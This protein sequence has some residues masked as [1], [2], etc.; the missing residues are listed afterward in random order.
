MLDIFAFIGTESSQI[1]QRR[2]DLTG[3]LSLPLLLIH[4]IQGERASGA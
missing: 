3:V 1:K 2:K 4:Q